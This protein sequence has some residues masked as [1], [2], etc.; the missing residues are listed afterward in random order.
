LHTPLPDEGQPADPRI[1]LCDYAFQQ[2]AHTGEPYE[3]IHDG[4]VVCR[5][6]AS[7]GLGGVA[8]ARCLRRAALG[9]LIIDTGGP[10]F[11]F[12]EY[13]PNRFAVQ[14]KPAP[15]DSPAPGDMLLIRWDFAVIDRYGNPRPARVGAP[16][17]Y[18][19]ETK[20]HCAE[21]FDLIVGHT[22]TDRETSLNDAGAV[23]LSRPQPGRAPQSPGPEWRWIEARDGERSLEIRREWHQLDPSY[24]TTKDGLLWLKD[25]ED[26]RWKDHVLPLALRVELWDQ[27]HNLLATS[28]RLAPGGVG[29]TFPDLVWQDHRFQ[30]VLHSLRLQLRNSAGEPY[31]N[32]GYRL[33][34]VPAA[35]DGAPLASAETDE[36]GNLQVV[37]PPGLE[38]AQL[39]VMHAD[40]PGLSVKACRLS[41]KLGCLDPAQELPGQEARLNDLGFSASTEAGD[42]FQEESQ[43]KRFERAL[44]RFKVAGKLWPKDTPGLVE[45]TSSVDEQTSSK[46]ETEHGS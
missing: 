21:C 41:L 45:R 17:P 22:R 9:F 42:G 1:H 25:S 5:L 14:F 43:R 29:R 18:S 11:C 12:Y 7:D 10:E 44:Q 23:M 39:E 13:R 46:L 4:P 3:P 30:F 37:I 31:A 24:G 16:R 15:G 38:S 20:V 40:R 33:E 28:D 26:G 34:P 27:N 6:V 19:I 35:P 32:H 36:H 2:D 8:E